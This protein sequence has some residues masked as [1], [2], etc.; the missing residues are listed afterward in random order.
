MKT[1]FRKSVGVLLLWCMIVPPDITR[2]ATPE[3][4]YPLQVVSKL[5]CRLQ[6][7]SELDDSCKENIKILNPSD[8]KT[9]AR[10]TEWYNDYTRR[11][12]VLWASSYKY[13]WDVW[14][15][16]HMWVDIA[17]AKWTPVYAMAEWE[18]VLSDSKLWF[19][20]I[21]SIKHKINWKDIVSNYAHL[22]KIDVSVW[23]KV[24]AWDKIWE[25]WSTGNSTWNHLHFQID[26]QL[27]K[28]PAYYSY[29]TCPYTYNDIVEN[30]RCFNELQSLT[31]DP[32]AFLETSWAILNNI[33]ITTVS[34]PTQTTST[35][36]SSDTTKTQITWKASEIF[37]KQIYIWSSFD[38]IVEVQKIYRNIWYYNWKI[39]WEYTS[40]L[41]SVIKY[42]LEKW[43]IASTDDPGTGQFWP[44]TRAQTKKD[45]EVYLAKNSLA[46]QTTQVSQTTDIEKISREWMLTRE[47]I[48]AREL[49]EF[50]AKYDIKIQNNDVWNN[51]TIWTNKVISL[52]ISNRNGRDF[53]WNT[54]YP[55]T[56]NYDSDLISVFPEKFY[57]Y[58]D[59]KRD[60]TITWKKSWDVNLEIK[61]WSKTLNTIKLRVLSASEQKNVTVKEAVSIISPK[62]VL[63]DTNLW[64]VMLK[65]DAWNRL[66]N[67]RYNWEFD[68]KVEWNWEICVKSWNLIDAK[69][70]VK[71]ECNNYVKSKK[72]TYDDT[73]WWLLIFNYR[74]YDRN[75]KIKLYSFNTKKDL[76]ASSVKTNPP[77]WLNEN[78][79][80]YDEIIKMMENSTLSFNLKQWYFL[81]TRNLTDAEA[82]EWIKNTLVTMKENTWDKTLKTKL[83]ANINKINTDI[84]N[85]NKNLTRK[86]FLDK[87]YN[88]LV[89]DKNPQISINYKDLENTDNLK[90]NSVFDK[91]NTWKDRFWEE[92]YQPTQTITRW[93]WAF[94]L[95][96]AY[97][98]TK[99]LNVV[100]A[101]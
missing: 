3:V 84:W 40:V 57:N 38:D 43:V 94:L 58:T 101:Q 59:G 42:Q 78:Y 32:L 30:W 83:E 77:R 28:S 73:V 44:K 76:V 80:Y 25:V 72:I 66:I 23:A 18:V 15:W 81:E 95:A 93:E 29:D 27:W 10:M 47:E 35:T 6:D 89:F 87:V 7:F 41:P 70:I 82:N 100:Y 75:A 46:N 45:Y 71:Q 16:G 12:S 90:A 9:Y 60:I 1:N 88:Y 24:K 39:D 98:R 37:N 63:W 51:I 85:S 79:E 61:M 56:F 14:N 65:D 97:D 91:N 33:T 50:E 86:E 74:I 26:L 52:N 53:R 92:Y 4:V 36:T 55:I 67:L 49:R 96:K 62:V 31:V 22:S 99:V 17:T 64:A 68:L 21:V 34:R 69:K 2:S 20:N 48:E 5:E 8:Y 19:W 13:W 11:Y 54:P